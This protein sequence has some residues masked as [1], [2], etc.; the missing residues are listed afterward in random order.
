MT[1]FLGRFDTCG[2]T[3]RSL[4]AIRNMRREEEREERERK[5]GKGERRR[6]GRGGTGKKWERR[7]T[8]A[9]ALNSR[10]EDRFGV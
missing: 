9:E 6:Q 8:G 2:K 4:E 10:T 5:R 1:G 7:R 3:E